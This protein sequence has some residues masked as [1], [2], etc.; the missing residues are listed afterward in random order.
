MIQQ[1]SKKIQESSRNHTARVGY[2]FNKEIERM[3]SKRVELGRKSISMN[4]LTNL[5]I[6]HNSWSIIIKDLINFDLKD[7]NGR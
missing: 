4:V 1:N 3:N 2:D 7:K 6:K 5:L